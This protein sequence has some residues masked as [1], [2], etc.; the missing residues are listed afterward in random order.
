VQTI[1]VA[2]AADYSEGWVEDIKN[3]KR[4]RYY[5]VGTPSDLD[6]WDLFKG[7]VPTNPWVLPWG[8]VVMI[9]L[10]QVWVVQ[11][12][13][14]ALLAKNCGVRVMKNDL[15]FFGPADNT[16]HE[17]DMAE[18]VLENVQGKYQPLPL[19]TVSSCSNCSIISLLRLQPVIL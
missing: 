16:L 17:P 10:L 19:L 18:F 4:G 11:R 14:L 9:I 2:S 7:R 15:E 12:S 1:Y 3:G 8:K 5:A 6:L 13:P